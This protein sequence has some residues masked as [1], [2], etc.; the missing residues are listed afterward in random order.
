MQFHINAPRN[1]HHR[2]APKCMRL[3]PAGMEINW[4]IPGNETADE[5]R[6]IAF[7]AEIL[8]CALDLLARQQTQVSE[9]AVGELIDD[10]TSE[11]HGQTVVDD[12]ADHGTQAY[13]KAR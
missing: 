12:G 9:F 4:R 8:L 2:N 10:N 7:L 13:R 11:P 3:R 5:R 1:V 6:Y